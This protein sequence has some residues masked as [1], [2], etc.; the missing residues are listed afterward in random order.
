MDLISLI[1]VLAVLGLV[2]YLVTTFIPMSPPFKT[3]IVVICVIALCIFLLQWAG[4]G[5][6][7]LRG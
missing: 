4:L 3:V 1:I 2:V 7:R 6:V 5:H